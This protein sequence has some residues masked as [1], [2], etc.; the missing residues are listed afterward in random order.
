MVW[1]YEEISL[2]AK[3]NFAMVT[4]TALCWVKGI[5]YLFVIGFNLPVLEC[6]YHL[7]FVLAECRVYI[8]VSSGIPQTNLLEVGLVFVFD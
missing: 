2:S 6:F 7:Y 5:L 3:M 4:G 8:C 1:N